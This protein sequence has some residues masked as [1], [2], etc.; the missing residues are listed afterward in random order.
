MRNTEK[1]ANICGKRQAVTV[2]G[3]PNALFAR[4]I[5]DLGFEVV[6][7]TGAG[8]ANMQL[9]VPDLGLTTISEVSNTVASISDVVEL[10]IIVDADTG[11]GNALNVIRTIKTLE[12]SGA[13]GIQIEDQV[14][15]KRCGHFGGK[16]V[17]SKSEMVQKIHAAVDARNDQSL[18]IIAR[19]D[20][21]A[22]EGLSS[23]I[24]RAQSYIDAGA[25]IT[26]VEAPNS[27]MELERI[28]NELQVP[29]IANIVYGGKTPDVGKAQLSEFGFSL[30]LYANAI[31]QAALKASHEVLQSLHEKGSLA[32]VTEKLASF[33]DRQAVV[34]KFDWDKLEKKYISK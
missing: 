18:Q 30:V 16:E 2:P 32:A 28:A 10:P 27:Q 26:F 23:A 8:I 12:K 7:V 33:D 1:L 19:T 15:P 5:E 17:I 22:V 21:A 20:A 13:S 34:K 6:Y 11:F 31:L 4:L 9:G 24:D 29:Q 14:F 25:D 3:A